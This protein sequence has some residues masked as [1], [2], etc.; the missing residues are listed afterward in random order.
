[1]VGPYSTWESLGLFVTQ[2]MMAPETV[3]DEA[4]TE[5]MS[6]GAGGGGALFTVTVTGT[7]AAI[8]P[9]VLRAT[10]ARV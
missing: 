5:E 2:V 4:T 9:A 3:I 8:S 1:M 10:A 7:A 6:V